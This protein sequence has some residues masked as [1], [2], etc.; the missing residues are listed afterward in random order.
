MLSRAGEAGPQRRQSAPT[1]MPRPS[2]A[3]VPDGKAKAKA[4]DWSTLKVT[5]NKKFRAS[6]AVFG[7]TTTRHPSRHGHTANIA[8][9]AKPVADGSPASA[10]G[11]PGAATHSRSDPRPNR[12]RVLP[13]TPKSGGAAGSPSPVLM[14]SAKAA[15]T[16]RVRLVPSESP[17]PS[18]VPS[19]LGTPVDDSHLEQESHLQP[20]APHS[21]G[22]TQ[23]QFPPPP[24][25]RSMP[26]TGRFIGHQGMGLDRY[27]LD[28]DCA[29]GS[30][31]FSDVLKAT[32]N[33]GGGWCGSPGAPAGPVAIKVLRDSKSFAK[34]GR[35]EANML[36]HVGRHPGLIEMV[37][38]FLFHGHVCLVFPLEATTLLHAT[39]N[40]GMGVATMARCA[41]DLLRALSH[42]KARGVM[43]CDIKPD[44][45]TFNPGTGRGFKLIDFGCAAVDERFVSAS[46]GMKLVGD[47]DVIQSRWYRAPEVLFRLQPRYGPATDMWSLACTLYEALTG[48]PLFEGKDEP[49][50]LNRIVACLGLPPARLVGEANAEAKLRG[51]P[52]PLPLDV[53]KDRMS[54]REGGGGVAQAHGPTSPGA[55]AINLS[56]QR[57]LR[58]TRVWQTEPPR[59]VTDFLLRAL[60][61]NPEDR[62][63]PE[64]LLQHPFLRSTASQLVRTGRNGPAQSRMLRQN[65][66]GAGA[67][68]PRRQD[69]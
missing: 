45:I 60:R 51:T 8:P 19:A 46:T 14:S 16:A 25:Y 66:P 29:L 42:L 12:K 56:L 59:H 68:A 10:D 20:H 27:T 24:L 32:S 50:L 67:S 7:W 13:P 52:P 22:T 33:G 30:G 49:D 62:A 61:W 9:P 34:V 3:V 65:S 57:V 36:H 44:N 4:K 58:R 43:H 5:R 15:P 21:A 28:E 48:F 17:E 6:E 64:Q 69:Y 35:G 2:A 54:H 23:S 26:G 41:T 1:F 55:R 18:P 38:N 39:Q 40:Q 31:S 47:L 11:S 63:S 53:A 37:D